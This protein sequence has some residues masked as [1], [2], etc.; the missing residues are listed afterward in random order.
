LIDILII[1]GLV[2]TMDPER[3]II[4]DGSIAIEG[5]KIIDIG[6]T[7]DLRKNH[8]AD[9]IIDA[10]SSIVA[11]GLIDSHTHHYELFGRTLS[12][13]RNL[14]DWLQNLTLPLIGAMTEEDYRLSALLG[15]IENIK[16]GTTCIV[17]N[18]V[19]AHNSVEE[20]DHIAARAIDESGIRGFL[21]RGILETN[22]SENFSES[23]EDAIKNCRDLIEKWHGKDKGRIRIAIGPLAPWACSPSLLREIQE[24]AKKYG[25]N[26]HMHVAETQFDVDMVKKEHGK[27]TIEFLRDEGCLGPHIQLA[28]CVWV[29]DNEI[30]VIR[31]TKTNVIHN[32]VANMFLAE[33]VAPIPRMLKEGVN[34]GLGSDGPSTNGKQDMFEVMKFATCLAKV[35]T[36]DPLSISTEQVLEMATINGSRTLGLENEIGSLEVGKKADLITINPNR[37]HLVPL[38][39]IPSSL[40]Y[41][42]SGSDV[43]DVIIDGRMVM[44]KRKI[45]T[46]DEDVII[47]DTQKAFEKCSVRAGV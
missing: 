31:D 42:I 21:A 28:H 29:T 32:P 1:N 30:E 34:V 40:V 10:G 37:S 24:L 44:E 25:I 35:N 14:G 47:E 3:R 36:L 2:I 18:Y 17:D 8:K 41:S 45:L 33:G 43:E 26:V 4:K 5:N 20:S 13:D 15:C 6:R 7:D 9:R 19:A 23:K 38:H 16:M 11:P 46:L 27:N 22:T 12:F 39:N